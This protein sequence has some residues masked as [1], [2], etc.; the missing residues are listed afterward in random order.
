ME[1]L[2]IINLW[3]QYDEKLEKSLSLNQKILVEL[4]QQKAKNALKPARNYKYIAVFVGLTYIAL[5]AYFLYHLSSF[6]S[7]FVNISVA[8]HLLVTII[9]VGMYIRQLVLISEIDRS[10]DI[11][12]MQQKMAKL[13][14]STLKVIAVC[15]LQFPVFATWN[16]NFELIDKRPLA[17]WLIQVPIVALFTYVGV[18]FY[19]N[20]NLK[21]I[22]KRWFRMM[23][24]GAEW[25]AILKSGKFMEEIKEFERN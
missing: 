5:I 3:K 12:Q 20:I 8:I 7:I 11:L 19:K 6:A 1:N 13:K 16:I 14:S 18:W 22:N 17:F 15:F 10:E 23:F 2:E 25:N 24:Y 9:A 21:N 4:Q